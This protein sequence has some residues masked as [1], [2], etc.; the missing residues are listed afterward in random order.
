MSRA[1]RRKTGGTRTG[2]FAWGPDGEQP[3]VVEDNPL[4]RRCPFCRASP[5]NPCTRPSRR[6]PQPVD[7]H[8]S[9][10]TPAPAQ[11]QAPVPAPS[12]AVETRTDR[13]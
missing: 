9:R 10:K 11:P 5:G 12:T 7:P 3:D 1:G 2:L 6:G 8:D 13:S 4:L